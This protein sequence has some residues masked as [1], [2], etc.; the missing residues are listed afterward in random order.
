MNQN[1]AL[2]RIV[3]YRVK[4]SDPGVLLSCGIGTELPAIITRVVDRAVGIV[5]LQVF[6]DHH[7]G[8]IEWLEAV[9][10]GDGNGNW[11]WPPLPEKEEAKA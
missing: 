2:G 11:S 7:G 4:N 10:K 5:N 1:L 3:R 6:S 9:T 8:S